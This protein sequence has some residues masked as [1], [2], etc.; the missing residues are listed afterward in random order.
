[1]ISRWS[2]SHSSWCACYIF[3]NETNL[4]VHLQIAQNT[5]PLVITHSGTPDL[6]R[7]ALG[8][9]T[10]QYIHSG[11][12]LYFMDL[13]GY[14]SRII[15]ASSNSSLGSPFIWANRWNQWSL[16]GSIHPH[17]IAT[18]SVGIVG[19]WTRR[20]MS[21]I[22]S[23]NKTSSVST[24]DWSIKTNVSGHLR[25]KITYSKNQSAADQTSDSRIVTDLCGT[26]TSGR[27][28]YRLGCPRDSSSLWLREPTIDN[29]D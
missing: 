28:V 4:R 8:S 27:C 14:L 17:R 25:R 16:D 18:I 23:T 10:F 12:R 11:I 6:D 21:K 29:H 7:S 22:G 20:S 1:M 24:E 15:V 2:H 19:I 5:F 3:I 13:I 26:A 9:W